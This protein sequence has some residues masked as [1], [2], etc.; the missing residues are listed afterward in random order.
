MSARR[1]ASFHML[2]NSLSKCLMSI[3][4]DW[5][6][7]V[8]LTIVF[9][10]APRDEIW[11]FVISVENPRALEIS[12]IRFDQCPIEPTYQTHLTFEII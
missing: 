4:H 12:F 1:I 11:A 5:V 10:H 3:L 9:A 7:I 8:K 6:I 2:F